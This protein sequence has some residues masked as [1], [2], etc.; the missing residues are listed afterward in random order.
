M[1]EIYKNSPKESSPEWRKVKAD[2]PKGITAKALKAALPELHT[3]LLRSDELHMLPTEEE[4]MGPQLSAAKPKPEGGVVPVR[5]GSSEVPAGHLHI[6]EI[7][8]LLGKISEE[9]GVYLNCDRAY[10]SLKQYAIIMRRSPAWE[11]DYVHARSH[12]KSGKVTFYHSP[13][14]TKEILVNFVRKYWRLTSGER[15]ILINAIHSHFK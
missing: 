14:L 2:Y 1:S 10:S 4:L 5:V 9:A 11:N 15:E 6:S 8:S 3:K 12:T 7:S 13:V